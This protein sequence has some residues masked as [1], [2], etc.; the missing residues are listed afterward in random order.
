MGDVILV[1]SQKSDIGKT[2]IAIKTGIIISASGKNVLLMDLSSGKI[3]ISE[4]LEVNEDIIYDIKDVLDRTCSIEQATIDI[5]ENLHLLPYPRISNKLGTI[6]AQDFLNLINGLKI[7]YDVIIVDMDS[8]VSCNYIEYEEIESLITVNNNDYSSI[9]EIN[10]EICISNMFGIK[11]VISIIN[12]YNSKSS[13]LKV[14]DIKKMLK[15]DVGLIEEDSK[16]NMLDKNFLF[17]DDGSSFN[18]T[19]EAII[20]K[21]NTK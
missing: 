5:N 18:K 3:K 10:D 1:S 16:Y 9:K 19:V 8:I 15:I 2:V 7:N 12:K 20:S 11:N 14:K 21:L 4:Y 13:L 17:K 6:K